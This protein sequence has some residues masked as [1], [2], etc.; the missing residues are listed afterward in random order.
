M[1]RGISYWSFQHGLAG[2]HPIPDALREARKAGFEALELC[3]GT[4]G[5]LSLQSTQRDCAEVRTAI[6][7]AGIAVETVASGLSWDVC[8]TDPR[9]SVRRQAVAQHQAALQRAAWLG[10]KAM[11]FVPGAIAIPWK[12]DFPA[13]RY[14]QAV[15]WAGQAVAALLVT[16]R[17]LKVDLCIENVW[18]GLFYSPLEF[19]DFL[20]AWGS[21]R[22]KAYF[23][24]GNVLGYH[25]HPQHWIEI[26]GKRIGRVHVKDFKRAAGNLSGFC[27]LGD[28][29]VPW[30]AVSAALKRTGYRGTAI[31][32]MM[33]WRPD[34]LAKTAKSLK[35]LLP[36]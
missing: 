18:N 25:Q 28:G 13:V 22:V 26:L 4:Q 31:A 21:E 19:R 36:A 29:D 32:E 33:P 15:T 16:A 3:I 2:T 30:K 9:A 17:K 6:D 14:D 34:L 1:L 5:A 35:K 20:D 24:V 7:R 12:P 23:D 27:D 8:P 11:L 10:C